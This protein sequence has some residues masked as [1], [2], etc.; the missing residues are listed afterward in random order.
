M[1]NLTKQ[2]ASARLVSVSP[3]GGDTR[4]S[5]KPPEGGAP[6]EGVNP[7]LLQGFHGG[8]EPY[9]PYSIEA[10]EKSLWTMA[11]VNAETGRK[12]FKE[13]RCKS[14]RCKR[15][16]PYVNRI[17]YQ[18]IKEALAGSKKGSLGFVTFTFNR[19]DWANK[20]ECW[21]NGTECWKRFRDRLAYHYGT[22]GRGGKRARVRYITVF[23]QHRD[24]WP[25][26]HALIESAELMADVE[27]WGTRTITKEGK[28]RTIHRI[29]REVLR[30]MY[31]ASGFGRVGDVQAPD[32]IEGMAGYLVKL[33]A[34]LTGSHRK[35][36]QT[37]IHAPHGFR[38]LRATPGFLRSRKEP[39]VWT[40]W[41]VPHTTE[42]VQ[43]AD[44][45]GR[46]NWHVPRMK[47]GK[48]SRMPRVRRFIRSQRDEAAPE[49][50]TWDRIDWRR[51]LF[52]GSAT[53]A[54]TD[55]EGV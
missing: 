54:I 28:E 34:E 55:P 26:L 46:F 37:P 47:D 14:W 48:E 52:T 39:G 41:L 45:L 11:L 36:D 53:S 51:L 43:E 4:T 6:Q 35:Q 7:A 15:C 2:D 20:E 32:S 18:R 38:R 25:H 9:Q 21:A 42:Q 10:C 22:R 3:P 19:R 31:T 17:E 12:V 13:F 29:N 23:E 40:G 8:S 1:S 33:A 30:P 50:E 44:S 27:R 24:G 5:L 16:A 49:G